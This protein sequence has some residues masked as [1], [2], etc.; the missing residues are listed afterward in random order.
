MELV[1]ARLWQSR[2]VRRVDRLFASSVNSGEGEM[3]TGGRIASKEIRVRDL[4]FVPAD[5]RGGFWLAGISFFDSVIKCSS[6]LNP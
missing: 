3:Y 2:T 6:T 5:L 1:C 4:S